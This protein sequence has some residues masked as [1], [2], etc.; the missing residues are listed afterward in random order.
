MIRIIPIIPM[1]HTRPLG[2]LCSVLCAV[3]AS[4]DIQALLGL[5]DTNGKLVLVRQKSRGTHKPRS[6]CDFGPSSHRLCSPPSPTLSSFGGCVV[7][8][9]GWCRPHSLPGGCLQHHR[10]AQDPGGQS[11]RRCSGDTGEGVC[12]PMCVEGSSPWWLVLVHGNDVLALHT[13]DVRTHGAAAAVRLPG[14][15]RLLR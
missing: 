14:D 3:S 11:H 9:P 10:R 4:H 5:V 1:S 8:C 7:V 13:H 15:A 12:V 6:T 2:V